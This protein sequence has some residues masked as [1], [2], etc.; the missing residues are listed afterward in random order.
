[1]APAHASGS[2][3]ASSCCNGAGTASG[4]P[5]EAQREVHPSS[6]HREL[7]LS[8][9]DAAPPRRRLS[10]LCQWSVPDP[11][12]GIGSRPSPSRS[13]STAEPEPVD[14]YPAVLTA[15]QPQCPRPAPGRS[16]LSESYTA[17]VPSQ[18]DHDTAQYRLCLSSKL[19]TRACLDSGKIGPGR[20]S[21][22]LARWRPAWLPGWPAA[23]LAPWLAGW[24]AGCLPACLPACL[25]GWPAGWLAGW[26]AGCLPACLLA[27]APGWPLCWL[28]GCLTGCLA[29]L[30][31]GWL[32]G[33]LSA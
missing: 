29:A 4:G 14:S 30:L 32:A 11:Q 22:G 15:L 26:L 10:G 31:A 16:L 8:D 24:L 12:L 33:W 3:G 21:A 23:C 17:L 19:T 2:C 25:P 18:L 1:M 28:A 27:C 5:D 7:R 6:S 13:L 9:S 20:L